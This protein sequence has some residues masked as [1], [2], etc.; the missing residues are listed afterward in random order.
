[1]R[2]LKAEQGG[3]GWGLIIVE[4]VDGREKDVELRSKE[5]SPKC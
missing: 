4:I 3:H 5:L 2:A 1:M